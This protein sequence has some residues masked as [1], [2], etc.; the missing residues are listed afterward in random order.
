MKSIQISSY[1]LHT[2]HLSFHFF[3]LNINPL[4]LHPSTFNVQ[5][6]VDVD[7]TSSAMIS[8]SISFTWFRAGVGASGGTSM[9]SHVSWKGEFVGRRASASAGGDVISGLVL[10]CIQQLDDF[11]RI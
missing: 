5:S 3:Y 1:S 4:T 7:E 11:L 2:S 9:W 8:S 10:G 6:I